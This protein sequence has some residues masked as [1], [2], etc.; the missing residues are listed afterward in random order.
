MSKE[1]YRGHAQWR[2]EHPLRE[3]QPCPRCGLPM[4]SKQKLDVGHVIDAARGGAYGP[5]R[6][7]HSTC[8]RKAGAKLGYQ[9]MKAKQ[10][11]KFNP[12]DYEP[13]SED[14]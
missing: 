14:W 10:A 13:H 8:N 11:G 3:G 12:A 1:Y 5:K 4:F 7:E 2:K 6:W 9:I